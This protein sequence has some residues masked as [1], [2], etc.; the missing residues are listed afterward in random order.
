MVFGNRRHG[1]SVARPRH[2]F[3]AR[4]F[5]PEGVFEVD[6]TPVHD[7]H[8][9]DEC[10]D[11]FVADIGDSPARVLRVTLQFADGPVEFADFF[12]EFEALGGQILLVQCSTRLAGL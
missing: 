9:Q 3:V 5:G 1:C 10:V 4:L 8:E 2:G 7:R 12:S 11:G 6:S